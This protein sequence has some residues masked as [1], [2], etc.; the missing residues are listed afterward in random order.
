MLP[1]GNMVTSAKLTNFPSAHNRQFVLNNASVNP[2]FIS[3]YYGY[4]LE[5]IEVLTHYKE[6]HDQVVTACKTF[7][8]ML[9]SVLPVLER[10]RPTVVINAK[11]VR[12]LEDDIES[13]M[14]IDY[15]ECG[16][17]KYA[18]V[19]DT[20]YRN[21]VYCEQVK[22]L[23]D[24]MV[25]TNISDKSVASVSLKDIYSQLSTIANANI[26]N[27]NAYDNTL[28]NLSKI[29]NQDK[30]DNTMVHEGMFESI[31]DMLDNSSRD[32]A[33]FLPANSVANL[34]LKLLKYLD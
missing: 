22:T 30:Q 33:L 24:M 3:Q 17:Q 10:T 7:M 8:Q 16:Y 26:I 9:H 27:Q 15:T 4:I 19:L 28:Q 34:T 18:G 23:K 29:H 1:D 6:Q 25:F 21:L 32:H 2:N 20:M 31:F 5:V 14:Y 12:L 11:Q 13:L